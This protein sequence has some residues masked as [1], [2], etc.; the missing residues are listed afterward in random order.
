M[1]DHNNRSG[2]PARLNKIGSAPKLGPNQAAAKASK[3]KHIAADQRRRHKRA[4]A[5]SHSR[6]WP[7]TRR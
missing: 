6:M 1:Q 3:P 4:K 2:P 7:P 5:A